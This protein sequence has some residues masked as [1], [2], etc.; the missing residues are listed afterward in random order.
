M[1]V[2]ACDAGT[3][4]GLCLGGQS[5]HSWQ[6]RCGC[7]AFSSEPCFSLQREKGPPG[8]LEHSCLSPL[9]EQDSVELRGKLRVWTQAG[10][11]PCN[12][13]PTVLACSA[14]AAVWA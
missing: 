3:V 4:L 2:G 13:R 12:E 11:A 6:R 1:G 8:G 14:G 5:W 10:R 7:A 9:L